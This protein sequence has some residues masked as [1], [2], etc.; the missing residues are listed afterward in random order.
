MGEVLKKISISNGKFTIIDDEDYE[1]CSKYKWTYHPSNY[2]YRHESV[3]G[4]IIRVY[5]HR[6]LLGDNILSGFVVDHINGN[7]LDNRKQNL[8]IVTNKQN[9]RNTQKQKRH[10]SSIYKGVCW[11]KSRQKWIVHIEVDGHQ[12]YLGR[13]SSERDAAIAYNKAAMKYFGE[14]ACLNNI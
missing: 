10:T 14:Y 8:R 13:F 9:T 5:L 1:K 12:K 4:K 2:A 6:F 3:N 7:G 11:D